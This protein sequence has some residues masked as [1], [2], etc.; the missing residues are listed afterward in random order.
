MRVLEIF[1]STFRA[2]QAGLFS[3]ACTVLILFLTAR[4]WKVVMRI[5]NLMLA[6]ATLVEAIKAL[7]EFISS[8]ISIADNS[9]R[10]VKLCM[11][12]HQA[13]LN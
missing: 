3:R 8:S 7:Q 4:C 12:S 9:T 1:S 11:A 6:I 10:L 13:F 5:G 2:D